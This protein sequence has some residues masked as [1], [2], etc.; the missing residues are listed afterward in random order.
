MDETSLAVLVFNPQSEDLFEGL[1]QW[2]RDMTRAARRRFRKLLVAGRCDRGGLMVSSQS[3]TG[4][5]EERGFAVYLET[6]ALTGEGCD[7]LRQTI[8][9]NIERLYQR[10]WGFRRR[11][12]R[13]KR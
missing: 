10:Y 11:D 4:F 5:M 7:E 9:G 6:S 3:L 1:G 13:M 8:I 2:D 12:L